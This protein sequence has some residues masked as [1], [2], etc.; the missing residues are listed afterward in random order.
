MGDKFD[1][2]QFSRKK[3]ISDS[4]AKDGVGSSNIRQR[5]NFG[6]SSNQIFVK[7]HYPAYQVASDEDL[8][9]QSPKPCLEVIDIA[10]TQDFDRLPIGVSSIMVEP[11][12]DTEF[13]SIEGSSQMKRWVRSVRTS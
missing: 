2:Y 4:M 1:E 11:I 8:N 9:H 10:I 5:N 12:S 3:S 6:D 7:D 13:S